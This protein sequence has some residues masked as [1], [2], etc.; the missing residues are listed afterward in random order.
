VYIDRTFFV[1][2]SL[3]VETET[4]MYFGQSGALAPGNGELVYAERVH[5]HL[6][7]VAVV[8][9]LIRIIQELNP[10]A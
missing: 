1:K 7:L 4:Q 3:V 9:L 6:L 10:I 2:S 5:T 8:V